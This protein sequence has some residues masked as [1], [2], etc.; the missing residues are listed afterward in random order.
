MRFFKYLVFIFLS[1]ISV[2]AFSADSYY[3]NYNNIK[4]TAAT[5]SGVCKAVEP[6]YGR[7][8]R[9]PLK[10]NSAPSGT[11]VMGYCYDIANN[12]FTVFKE[13]IKCPAKGWP[14]PVYLPKGTTRI[15]IRMCKDGCTLEGGGNSIETNNYTMTTMQFT[16]DSLNCT[17]AYKDDPVKCDTKDPYGDCYVPPN[18][19]CVRLKD[20]SIQCP[21]NSKPPENNTCNGADYC[22][23]PP[24]GCGP[25]YVPGSFNGEQLCVRSGPNTP[26]DPPE[27]DKPEDPNNCMNGGT[28]CPQPPDNTKCPSGYSETTFN[29]SKICV[30]DNPDPEKLNPNDPNNP[31]YGGGDNGG[32]DNGG[33]DG[34]TGGT[35]D[36]KGIIDAIKDL[37]TSL[38][39]A[40]AGISGKLDTIILGQKTGNEHLKNIKDESVKTNEKLDKSNGHLEKIE[41]AT[42]ATSEAVGITNEK[43]DSLKDSVDS[44]TKCRDD[45]TGKYRE[46]TPDDLKKLGDSN[47]TLPTSE[48]GQQSFVLD[49]FKVNAG[50]CP[51]D[52]HLELPTFAGTFSRTY[53]FQELCNETAW[54]GYIVLIL[55]YSFAVAIVLRA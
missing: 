37:K 45:S 34:S 54:F 11:T 53:S 50:Y 3:A 33:G 5:T 51:A 20:G 36:V 29:G 46:C 24:E 23:R 19:D 42:K 8:D 14:V 49:L 9:L 26:K 7:Q 25:G 4:Y 1:I 2:N 44:Q 16:G 41:E 30:K 15:P 38:L 35:I 32:G 55:A 40:I 48:I 39:N 10:F 17:E 22:K 28:Y 52:K 27:P 12:S 47:A 21:D 6:V 13:P 43:L 31:D 18:D